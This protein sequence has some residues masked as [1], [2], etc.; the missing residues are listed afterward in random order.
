MGVGNIAF[1][2][3]RPRHHKNGPMGIHVIYTTLGVILRNDDQH[4]L[5]VFGPG[6][7]M[8]NPTYRQVIIYHKGL[9]VRIAIFGT[10]PCP[11]IVG[12][13]HGHQLR[14]FFLPFYPFLCKLPFKLIHSVLVRDIHIITGKV[15]AGPCKQSLLHRHHHPMGSPSICIVPFF[16]HMCRFVGLSKIVERNFFPIQGFPKSTNLR[17][18]LRIYTSNGAWVPTPRSVREYFGRLAHTGIRL[19]PFVGNNPH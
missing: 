17:I 6:Q 7:K 9:W 19:Y 1:F 8:Q 3:I 15:V 4:I 10:Y 16:A 11:V 5:P 13:H 12:Q 18:I 2:H 14:H